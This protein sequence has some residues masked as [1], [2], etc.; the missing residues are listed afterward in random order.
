MPCHLGVYHL[1]GVES[2]LGDTVKVTKHWR[3]SSFYNGAPPTTRE[4]GVL[5]QF[6][7]SLKLNINLN[8]SLKF[9]HFLVEKI[10]RLY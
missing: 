7:N 1:L 5:G 10:L 6:I 8:Y 2:G 9:M 4:Q 3:D